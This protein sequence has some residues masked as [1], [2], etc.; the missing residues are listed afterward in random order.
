[1]WFH[2]MHVFFLENAD[3]LLNTVV[4]EWCQWHAP[5]N[6][7]FSSFALFYSA[8][9]NIQLR[10]MLYVFEVLQCLS[11]GPIS[12]QTCL[13]TKVSQIEPLGPT[14]IWKPSIVI[15]SLYLRRYI[16]RIEGGVNNMLIGTRPTVRN[17]TIHCLLQEISE[18]S[19]SVHIYERSEIPSSHHNQHSTYRYLPVKCG[20]DLYLRENVTDVHNTVV[21]PDRIHVI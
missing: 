20:T 12:W 1:M 9:V 17:S 6:T 3:Q 2:T 7:R 15:I 19:F 13:P 11:V 21:S 16:H 5:M 10:S 14:H 18:L 4:V 8:V